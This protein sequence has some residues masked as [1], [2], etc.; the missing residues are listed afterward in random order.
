MGSSMDC[1]GFFTQTP[2]DMDLLMSIASGQDTK[3]MTTLPDYYNDS[4]T[5]SIDASSP[6]THSSAGDTHAPSPVRV[7]IIKEFD[8]EAVAPEI[9]KALK[10]KC[11]KLE[12]KGYEIVEL[13]MP[14]LNMPWRFIILFNLLKW[15][16][17]F[18]VMTAFAMVFAQKKQ[19]T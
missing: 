10:E 2:E 5:S 14:T 8:N 18:L 19:L 15:P 17:I 12:E 16:Q 7:G 3:D 11:K 4:Q 13:E 9:R 6:A 1:V